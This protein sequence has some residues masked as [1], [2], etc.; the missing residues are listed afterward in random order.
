[1][2]KAATD[3][4]RERVLLPTLLFTQMA[5]ES[6][7]LK[8]YSAGSLKVGGSYIQLVKDLTG[9]FGMMQYIVITRFPAYC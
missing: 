2:L 6:N 4:Q 8:L 9:E 7:S 5:A 1:M 3:Q